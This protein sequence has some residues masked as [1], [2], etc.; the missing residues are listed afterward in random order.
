MDEKINKIIANIKPR[1]T[2]TYPPPTYSVKD[3]ITIKC[4]VNKKIKNF[5]AYISILYCY[6]SILLVHM[7][8]CRWRRFE[9]SSRY[10][11]LC[12]GSKS[13][14]SSRYSCDT[15]KMQ[16]PMPSNLVLLWNNSLCYHNLA[17]KAVAHQYQYTNRRSWEYPRTNRKKASFT[18]LFG[19]VSG[20]S[21]CEFSS[22]FCLL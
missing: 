5:S 13:Q 18:G 10:T 7:K 22:R 2:I 21:R 3:C 16:I 19:E 4:P 11:I 20:Y 12:L 9:S 8:L 15:L 14:R 1:W 6:R 17:W